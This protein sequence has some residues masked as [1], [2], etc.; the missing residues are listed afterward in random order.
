MFISKKELKCIK[1]NIDRLDERIDK[2]GERNRELRLKIDRLQA[3]YRDNKLIIKNIGSNQMQ[4]LLRSG[5]LEGDYN[6]R[7]T[8]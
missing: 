2:L 3:F 1:D 6:E 7:L 5:L 8:S 4:A